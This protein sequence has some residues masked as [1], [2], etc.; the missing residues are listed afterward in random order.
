MTPRSVRRDRPMDSR[1]DLVAGVCMDSDEAEWHA[2]G[3]PEPA[4]CR[5][6]DAERL[7]LVAGGVP[8]REAAARVF[9]PKH[10]ARVAA[11]LAKQQ[12]PK[13]ELLD[14]LTPVL[15]AVHRQLTLDFDTDQLEVAA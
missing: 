3:C 8:G 13:R 6:L 12:Q 11:R 7:D 5:A 1:R 14:D 10:A 9:T 2:A 15:P 4:V